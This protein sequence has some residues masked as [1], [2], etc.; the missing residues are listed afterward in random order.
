VRHPVVVHG[1]EEHELDYLPPWRARDQVDEQAMVRWCHRKL[2]ELDRLTQPPVATTKQEDY[3]AWLANLGP[4]IERKDVE[5]IRRKL[6]HLAKFLFPP[7]RGHGQGR[8]PRPR[9][10]LLVDA[11][12]RDVDRIKQLWREHYNKNYR[13]D[14]DGPSAFEIAML[15]WWP[16]HDRGADAVTVKEVIEA[17]KRL[18]EPSRRRS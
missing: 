7:K 15:R 17:H 8:H 3:V 9:N 11:A 2:D 1:D 14:D 12:A 5:A 16:W 6:P 4:E 13:R 18:S 10:Y